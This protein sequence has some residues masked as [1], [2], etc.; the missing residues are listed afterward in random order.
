[1][2]LAAL[3][4]NGVYDGLGTVAIGLLL[5]VVA[6]ILAVETKSLLLGESASEPAQRRIRDALT[7]TEGVDRVIHLKTMHL[8]PEEL[9][10]AVKVGVR[11]TDSAA[12]VAAAID[13][14]ELAVRSAE[15]TATSIYVEPDIYRPD[16]APTAPPS[17]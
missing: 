13:R 9:L 2:G 12:E 1:V 17:G 4:G 15:P 8:G 7:A 16:R 6:V 10:V 14:A 11:A 3:T 5:L